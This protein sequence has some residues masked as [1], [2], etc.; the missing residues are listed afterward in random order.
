MKFFYVAL[1]VAWSLAPCFAQDSAY[2]YTAFNSQDDTLKARLHNIIKGHTE[3]PYTSTSTDVWDIL[4]DTDKDTLNSSNV[5]LLYSNRSIDGPQEY[6]SGNGWTREHVWAKSRGDFGTTNGAGTDVHHLRPVDNGVNSTRNNRNFDECIT[7]INVIDNGFNT[8]SKRDANLWTFEP[9]DNVKGD[10]ARMIFYMAVRYEGDSGEPDLELTDALQDDT[11]KAPLHAVKTTLLGWN[12][13]DPVSTW[14]KNR[15]LIIYNDYQH[16][17]NPFID[18]PELAEHIWGDSTGVVW[19]PVSAVGIEE[20][21][22]NNFIVYPNPST[23]LIRVSSKVVADEYM[24]YDALG[25]ILLRTKPDSLNTMI[26][27]HHLKSG[28]YFIV[29]VSK[30]EMVMQK[31]LLEF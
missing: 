1:A 22:G 28:L 13:I 24:V 12:R 31:V 3:Y 6:N 4:Q 21:A 7:C 26:D 19:K 23:G 5:I 2:Y 16:N 14:E 8:G 11:A 27:L 17:R 9:P 10:V 29:K 20:L 18:Y 15:N 30:S 25:N